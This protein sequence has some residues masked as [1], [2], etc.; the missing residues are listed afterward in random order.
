MVKAL[1]TAL[2]SPNIPPEIVQTLLNLAEFMEHDDKPLPIDIRTLGAYA[3]K[4][5]AYAKA[6]HYKEMEFISEPSTDTIEAL[7][8]INNQLQQPDAAV[9]VLTCAQRNHNLDLKETWYEKL[10]RWDDALKAYEKKHK[11][12]PHNF[13]ITM[14]RMRCLHALGDWDELAATANCHWVLGS[15]EARN[16]IAPLA[17]AAA[18]GLTQWE[19]MDDYIAAMR[20]ESPEGAFF[21]AILALHRNQFPEAKVFIDHTRQLLDAEL[22]ALISES[23]SRAYG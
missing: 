20:P 6:L 14:G 16:N 10:H 7:I 15:D 17:A 13:E 1:E 12:D 3:S 23:Y 21:S 5:H 19:L 2:V 11:E 8:T 9:G 4:C 18:W 22:T